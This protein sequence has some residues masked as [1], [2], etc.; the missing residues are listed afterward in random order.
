MKCS[1]TIRN[2]CLVLALA[3]ALCHPSAASEKRT[4]TV[5][6]DGS[7]DFTTIQEAINSVPHHTAH[8]VT[9]LI[10]KGIY[11][12]KL[13]ITTSYITL[14]GEDR[15]STQIVYAELRKNWNLN[16]FGNDWGAAVVNIDSTV[17]DL[18]IV[19]LTIH[20][21]F[22]SLYTSDDHQFAIRGGGTRIMLLGCNVIADGGD[23]VSL[24]N[25]QSGMYYHADCYFEGGVDF[26]CPRGWC[27]V[28]SSRFYGHSRSASIWHDGSTKKDQKFVIRNS[29]FD[30]VPGFPLGRNHRDGQFFLL[31]C[32]FSSAMAD[33][34]IYR[35]ESSPSP[36]L[37]GPRYYYWN[38][39]RDGGDYS[40]F[41]DNLT[42]A[43][44]VPNASQIDAKWTFAGAWDPEAAIPSVV[45]PGTWRGTN[46]AAPSSSGRK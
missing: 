34:A 38:C 29:R 28:T 21:N 10:K 27:Y 41:A 22:G 20:N 26:V 12:E 44:G 33:K 2:I 35:P 5:A 16:R 23:T 40:W 6:K 25:R 46:T 36:F 39:H 24:W 42:A 11:H 17:T 3:A 19:N 9:I 30:G 1:V 37:W 45:P 14:A 43:E 32:T 7:G 31:D 4:I 8:T 15:D 18:T 13:Y